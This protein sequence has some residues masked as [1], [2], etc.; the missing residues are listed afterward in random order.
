MYLER[1]RHETIEMYVSSQVGMIMCCAAAAATAA[2]D[3]MLAKALIR[4]VVLHQK[5]RY[6]PETNTKTQQPTNGNVMTNAAAFFFVRI[7]VNIS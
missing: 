1:Y 6:T 5:F 4:C 3:P 7:N 2:R